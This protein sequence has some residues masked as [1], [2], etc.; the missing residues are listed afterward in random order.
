MT[1]GPGTPVYGIKTKPRDAAAAPRPLALRSRARD[2]N[3][4]RKRQRGFRRDFAPL[5]A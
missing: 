3:H 1:V 2:R 5:A 4:V